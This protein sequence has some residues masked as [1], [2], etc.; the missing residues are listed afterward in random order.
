VKNFVHALTRK[1]D[2][3]SYLKN[4]FS[5]TGEANIKDTF[6]SPQITNFMQDIT[7]EATLNPY[8]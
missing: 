6:F 3:F 1:S 2:G 8:E 5:R 7:S 4:K